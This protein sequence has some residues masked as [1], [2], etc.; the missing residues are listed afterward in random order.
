MIDYTK[1]Q[2]H[3]TLTLDM[4][5]VFPT[6]DI[7]NEYETWRENHYEKFCEFLFNIY[8]QFKVTAH[9]SDDF[10]DHFSIICDSVKDMYVAS[11]AIQLYL[12][13]LNYDLETI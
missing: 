11:E 2:T 7:E 12:Q 6:D 1:T 8:E 10:I 4:K 9:P 13:S 3:V 5:V